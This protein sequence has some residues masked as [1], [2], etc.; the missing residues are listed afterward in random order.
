M[1][2]FHYDLDP[3]FSMSRSKVFPIVNNVG[4]EDQKGGDYPTQ[5]IWSIY[6]NPWEANSSHYYS[7]V[8]V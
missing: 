2:N 8:L 6:P 7:Q 4:F 5:A 1:H 3:I